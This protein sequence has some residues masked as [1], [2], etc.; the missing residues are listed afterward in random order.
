MITAESVV[1]PA[2]CRCR[3]VND[4]MGTASRALKRGP[5]KPREVNETLTVSDRPVDSTLP[6]PPLNGGGGVVWDVVSMDDVPSPPPGGRGGRYALLFDAMLSLP[7]GHSVRVAC[8]GVKE[9]TYM[10]NNLKTQAK[11]DGK[12]LLSS[13]NA[14]NTLAWFWLGPLRS[15]DK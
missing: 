3:K 7:S 9:L 14:Q 10:R 4:S 13:R 15:I 1:R 6:T 2:Q 12:R 8:S 5:Y 11:R